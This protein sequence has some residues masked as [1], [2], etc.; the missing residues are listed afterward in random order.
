MIIKQLNATVSELKSNYD[1][2]KSQTKSKENELSEI[3]KKLKSI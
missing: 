3:K 1:V 2:S